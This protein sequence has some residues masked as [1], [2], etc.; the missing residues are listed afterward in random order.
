MKS[1]QVFD[2]T[3]PHGRQCKTGEEV[4]SSIATITKK[5]NTKPH[6]PKAEIGSGRKLVIYYCHADA[7]NVFNQDLYFKRAVKHVEEHYEDPRFSEIL[8]SFEDHVKEN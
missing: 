1:T 7:E 3:T 4:Y 5:T 2:S 6:Q 8:I